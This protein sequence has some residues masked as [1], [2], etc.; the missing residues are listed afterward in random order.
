[1]FKI[2]ISRKSQ[3]RRGYKMFFLGIFSSKVGRLR[4]LRR[5]I[6]FRN[7]RPKC[8]RIVR[9]KMIRLWIIVLR[10]VSHHHGQMLQKLLKKM[11]PC[12]SLW[13][14]DSNLL[15]HQTIKSQKR[16]M[17]AEKIQFHLQLD[18]TNQED[19]VKGEITIRLTSVNK[20]KL[21]LSWHIL[22]L[23]WFCVKVPTRVRI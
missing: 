3:E 5:Y 13:I 12:H 22:L 23:N 4:D 14:L 1:M 7:R 15:C 2:A 16:I 8:Q 10:S 19:V 18:S 17:I 9:L 11:Q 6:L 20:K 21:K